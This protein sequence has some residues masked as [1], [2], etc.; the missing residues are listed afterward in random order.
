MGILIDKRGKTQ[1]ITFGSAIILLIA[2]ILFLSMKNSD[3]TGIMA[4]VGI[5]F[6][7]GGVIGFIVVIIKFFSK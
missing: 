5:I 4:L 1:E 3:T 2:G 6:I 7:A